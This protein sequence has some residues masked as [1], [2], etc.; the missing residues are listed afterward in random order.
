M[1]PPSCASQ[2]NAQAP[3]MMHALSDTQV[4]VD[5]MILD[6]LTCLAIE[7]IL[8]AI[9]RRTQGQDIEEDA[10]NW[11]VDSLKGF[12]SLLA[13]RHIEVPLPQDLTI[14]LHLLTV[15][16]QLRHYTTEGDSHRASHARLPTIGM[17][18]MDL[19]LTATEK[20]SETRWFD[21]GA[22][23]IVQALLENQHEGNQFPEDLSKLCSWAPS[24]LAQSS[25][26]LSI[27]QRYDGEIS[28][29]RDPYRAKL[30]AQKYPFMEFKAIVM[31]FLRDLMTTL[32]APMLLQL[33]RGQL[34]GLSP[35][36]TQLLKARVG[37][38]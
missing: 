9:G 30:V 4:E 6:Y 14:K 16:D 7:S 21:T 34:I 35:E 17:A 24:Q 28:D 19:C 20:V 26:W 38:R 13:S 1:K 23:F 5:F 33:E 22:R 8:V 11:Q 15:A 29:I 2:S 32:D 27:R 25:K 3:V 31:N 18:F 10:L 36:E 37:L 12:R